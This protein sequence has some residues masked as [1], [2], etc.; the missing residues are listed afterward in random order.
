MDGSVLLRL[1][2][3][4]RERFVR[5]IENESPDLIHAHD[6]VTF[7]AAWKGA[8]R[9]DGG[10]KRIPWIAHVHS[11]E[12][13]R[14]PEGPDSL[15]ER[16]EQNALAAATAVVTP[17]RIT[18]RNVGDRYG[19]PAKLIHV[20][21]NVLSPERIDSH[22]T[23]LF[24]SARVVFL[25]RMSHQKGLDR[26]LDLARVLSPRNRNAEF[27]VYGGGYSPAGGGPVSFHGP[28]NW[29][30]RGEAFR[31][32]SILIVPSRAEPFG[33]VILEAML[34]R[35]PVIYPQDSGAAEV[36][37][38]GIKFNQ[39]DFMAI[40]GTAEKLL[41]DLFFWENVVEAQRK[42]IGHYSE[43]G[44]EQALIDLWQAAIASAAGQGQNLPPQGKAS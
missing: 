43:R 4:F 39:N 3:E 40:T 8:D 34:H 29:E 5:Y 35:V 26:F 12:M 37:T 27:H 15:V 32:S 25:G 11:I 21:P 42:E 33:M 44:F 20:V 36:L 1:I 38:S 30:R 18:A 2:D 7:E 28:L 24:E 17:S 19:I 6:W 9:V 23:G 31:D 13:E 22:E 41:A 16:M 14:R 10:R